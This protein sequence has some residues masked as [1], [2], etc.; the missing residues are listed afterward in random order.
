M[1]LQKL[2]LKKAK[3]I[4]LKLQK[5]ER[6][7]KNHCSAITIFGCAVVFLFGFALH[8]IV[9]NDNDDV[10]NYSRS[11]SY[12]PFEKTETFSTKTFSYSKNSFIRK[13][14]EFL[15]S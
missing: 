11:E 3:K 10:I 6:L 14:R 7:S 15:R 12:S 4:I 1:K 5:P 9:R 8:G 2:K 13:S